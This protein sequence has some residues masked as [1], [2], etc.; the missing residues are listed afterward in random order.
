M[1]ASDKQSLESPQL[2]D[3][4]VIPLTRPLLGFALTA[5]F[6]GSLGLGFFLIYFWF[7]GYWG[8]LYCGTG[9]LVYAFGGT[10]AFIRDHTAKQR[11]ILGH[12]RI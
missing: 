10:A 9:C 5:I 2:I 7:F 6:C 12:D 1:A 3:G 8:L 11:L 4:E